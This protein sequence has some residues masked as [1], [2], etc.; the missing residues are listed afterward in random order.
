[1]VFQED[2]ALLNSYVTRIRRIAERAGSESKLEGELNQLLKELLGK[3]G[4]PYDPAV[5][6][7]LK[8]LGLSQV[9]SDRPDS[10]FGHVV[11]DY[12]KPGLLATPAEVAKAKRKVT[13]Y[14]DTASGGHDAAPEECLKWAGIVWDGYE[15]L[16]CHSDGS[17]WHWSK[18]YAMS[19]GT[20]AS[21]VQTYRALHREPLTANRLSRYFGK[22]SDAA[23][24]LLR[25]MCSHLSKPKHRTSMLFREWRRLFQQVST[26]RL[27]QLPSLKE[28]ASR[29]G[30]ATHDA[31]QILFAL[32][33]YYSIVV[34]LLTSELLAATQMVA[35]SSLAADIANAPSYDAVYQRFAQLEH[36]DFYRNYRV[37]NFLEGDFF[38]W[39]THE[40]S[41]QLAEGLMAVARTLQ[42]FEPATAK[43]RPQAIKDLLKQFYSSLVDEQIRHDLGE[44]YTPDWLAQYVLDRIGYDGDPSKIVVDPACGSGT[45]LVE[46]ITRLRKRCEQLGLPQLD[47]LETI[48]HCVRGLDLNPLAVISARANYILSVAD[49]VF[50]LGHDIEIPVYLADAINVPVE[51]QHGR[52]NTSWTQQ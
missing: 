14:L 11:L 9:S 29:N 48:L 10:L 26:Y 38:S 5:N 23:R 45:F 2:Y 6:E 35:E 34:K 16:F 42:R 12:K 40:E 28:W 21:L 8:S 1:M 52:W 30:I 31:S 20:L 18:T 39:Y 27:S 13:G 37:T 33:T 49:L 43:L 4:I 36:S 41:P 22:D 15:I 7:T 17:G 47:T 50:E 25:T 3:H 19:E 44:Y 46:C 24:T 51:T 32:H